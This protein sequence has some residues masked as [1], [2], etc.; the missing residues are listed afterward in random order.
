M[1]NHVDAVTGHT[2]FYVPG[3]VSRALG[4]FTAGCVKLQFPSLR[5]DAWR[6]NG[7]KDMVDDRITLHIPSWRGRHHHER[8]HLCNGV[9]FGEVETAGLRIIAMN[10]INISIQT[11]AGTRS[12][13]WRMRLLDTGCCNSAHPAARVNHY[14]FQPIILAVMLRW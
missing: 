14:I 9:L 4:P 12:P 1:N 10:H 13:L 6:H 7:R 3:N 8:R 11:A 2:Q 5:R